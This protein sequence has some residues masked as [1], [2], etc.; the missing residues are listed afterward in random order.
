MNFEVSV[1]GAKGKELIMFES[2]NLTFFLPYSFEL[3]MKI[4]YE[5]FLESEELKKKK[6]RNFKRGRK[7]NKKS[8]VKNLL[9]VKLRERIENPSC[10][11][12]HFD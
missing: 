10:R 3:W 5:E 9:D 1:V 7:K 4:N 12:R 8:L 11:H 2:E 6:K